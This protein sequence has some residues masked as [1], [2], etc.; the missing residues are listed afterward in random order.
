V[1]DPTNYV[2]LDVYT[3]NFT[4]VA[5]LDGWYNSADTH[6]QTPLVLK[7]TNATP[8]TLA[9]TATIPPNSM[10]VHPGSEASAANGFYAVVG[11]KSPVSGS[12][13]IS[14]GVSDEDPNGGDGIAWSIDSYNGA[15]NT[16]LSSGSYPNGGSQ[17]FAS[18]SGGPSSITNIAVTAGEFLYFVIDPKADY[19][20]DS[21][22]L[23]VTIT[24]TPSSNV[25]EAPLGVIGLAGVGVMTTLFLYHRPRRQ[26]RIS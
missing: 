13:S 1:H 25:P 18:G 10:D 3:D 20:Y 11:W 19:L 2:A 6:A 26:R 5:G 14:G 4:G 15:T 8:V 17:P 22:N 9:G 23:D 7:N 16:T 24:A 12:V 21:T